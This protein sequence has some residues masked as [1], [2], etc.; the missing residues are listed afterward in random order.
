MARHN[1]VG[2]WGEKLA[3]DYLVSKGYAI[4]ETNWRMGHYEID[5]IAMH[6]NRIVFVE[7]KTRSDSEEDPAQAVDR[8]KM[9][10]MAISAEKYLESHDYHHEVQFDILTVVGDENRYVIEHIDDAFLPP[11]RTY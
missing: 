2:K 7:V 1:K 5:I 3:Y 10:R 4:S 6:K 9:S 8:R 11:L